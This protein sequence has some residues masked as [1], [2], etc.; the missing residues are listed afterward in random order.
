MDPDLIFPQV[1]TT[2]G[3]GVVF[4]HKIDPDKG[5]VAQ[6]GMHKSLRLAQ[7][8]GIPLPYPPREH[9]PLRHDV[10]FAMA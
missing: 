2:N 6:N 3:L 8:I 10:G 9:W 1:I 5:L 4:V 7:E